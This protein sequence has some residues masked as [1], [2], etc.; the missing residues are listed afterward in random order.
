MLESLFNKVA[1]LQLFCE[2]FKLIK[3]SFSHITPPVSASKKLN[4][5]PEENSSKGVIDLSF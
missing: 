5:L 4:N 2:Y 3:N 1:D